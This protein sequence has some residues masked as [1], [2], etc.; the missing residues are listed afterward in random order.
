MAV[1]VVSSYLPLREETTATSRYPVHPVKCLD[2]LDYMEGVAAAWATDNTIV[3]IEHDL[4]YDDKLIDDLVNCP[5]PACAYP[6][7]IHHHPLKAPFYCCAIGN[8]AKGWASFWV[9]CAW[10]T[11][12]DEWADFAAPGFIKVTPEA[13]TPIVDLDAHWQHVE[14]VINDHVTT[15]WHLHWPAVEHYHPAGRA[16]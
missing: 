1:V 7:L 2:E 13:R 5:E 6:Y 8:R 4:Q 3:N 10:V 11:P 15:R 14:F 16:Y 9:T 12:D